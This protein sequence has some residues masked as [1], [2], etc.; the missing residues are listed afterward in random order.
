MLA[1]KV[2]VGNRKKLAR[3][4]ECIP[5]GCVP[6]ACWLYPS[7]HEG[8]CLPNGV[9]AQGGLCPSMQFGRHP[10]PV[11]RQTPVK[12]TSSEDRKE[13][14]CILVLFEL[15]LFDFVLVH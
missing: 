8:V 5:V 7:I 13:D 6:P 2:Y 14:L 10:A 15:T 9:F 4:Q 1:L 12:I 3:K 11:D